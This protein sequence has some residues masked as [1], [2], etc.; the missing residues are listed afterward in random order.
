[1]HLE[2]EMLT[3]AGI[4]QREPV[5]DYYSAIIRYAYPAMESRSI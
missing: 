5:N 1:M 4:P 3:K 2:N